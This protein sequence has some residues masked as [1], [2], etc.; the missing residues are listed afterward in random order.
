MRRNDSP[1]AID[2]RT[3]RV[4]NQAPPLDGFDP[5]ACD[6]ALQGVIDGYLLRDVS[7]AAE[8]AGSAEAREPGRL[9]TENPTVL[10]THD[11]Y[12]NRIDGVEFHPSW[13]WRIAQA[14]HRALNAAPWTQPSGRA[15]L[16]RAAG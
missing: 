11:R 7:E 9:A 6:P 10:R 2:Y 15:H 12:G 16:R 5:L 4:T 14:I 8:P 13:H 1:P 3:H